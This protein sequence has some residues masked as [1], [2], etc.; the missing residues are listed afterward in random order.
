M[1]LDRLMGQLADNGV[2]QENKANAC[3]LTAYT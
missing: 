3:G 2:L 1:P